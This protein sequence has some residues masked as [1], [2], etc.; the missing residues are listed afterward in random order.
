MSYY[1]SWNKSQ[2]FLFFIALFV[3]ITLIVRD[4]IR[5]KKRDSAAFS[6]AKEFVIKHDSIRGVVGGVKGFGFYVDGHLDEDEGSSELVF[7][8]MGS[9]DTVRIDVQLEKTKYGGWIVTRW[10]F[11]NH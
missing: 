6:T 10:Y 5:D 1:S 9:K 3:T 4:F 7:D 2:K 11:K 8:V